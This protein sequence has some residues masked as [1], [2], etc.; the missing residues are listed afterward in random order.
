MRHSIFK[1]T[2]TAYG[3]LQIFGD[4]SKNQNYLQG[5]IN[6]RLNLESVQFRTLTQPVSGLKANSGFAEHEAG[7][8]I[9][10]PRSSVCHS[11]TGSLLMASSNIMLKETG[12]SR[13]RTTV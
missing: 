1:E 3:Y 6:I 7:V 4:N 8:I 5:E 2:L 10:E 12:I 9:A 11:A 13:D